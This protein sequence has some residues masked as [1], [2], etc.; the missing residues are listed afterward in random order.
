M[1][2]ILPIDLHTDWLRGGAFMFTMLAVLA[3]LKLKKKRKI[4]S[5]LCYFRGSVALHTLEQSG[6]NQ[7]NRIVSQLQPAR[8]C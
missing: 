8:R 2:Q 5:L 6:T 1:K 4:K 3:R 7:I